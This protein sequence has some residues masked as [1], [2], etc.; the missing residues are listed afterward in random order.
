M[1]NLK[2]LTKSEH[3]NAE[4]TAFMR[5]LIKKNIAPVQYYVYLKNQLFVYTTLE[6]YA[7]LK[8]IFEGE[9]SKLE[10]SSSLLQDVLEMESIENFNNTDDDLILLAA[11]DYVKYIEEIQDDKDRLFAHIYVRHMGDLS[12]G[13]MIKKLV[14]GPISFY[15]F[16][17]DT[18][19]LKGKIREKLHDGLVDEAK[20]CFSMVQNFLE[21]L[22]QYFNGTDA[23][24]VENI[25]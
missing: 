11:K 23:E 9:M 2:N 12:G 24:V 6:Y 13:Q 20:V 19:D 25:E 8:G 1:D 21:E 16:D 4:R 7:G 5:R 14:P 15:E 3:R 18:E 22:E 17:G 10:R